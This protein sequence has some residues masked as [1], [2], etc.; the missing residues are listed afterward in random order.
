[1]ANNRL[2]YCKAME[3][4]TFMFEIILTFSS[5]NESSTIPLTENLQENGLRKFYGEKMWQE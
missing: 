3:Q 4:V 1:M 5:T 2:R